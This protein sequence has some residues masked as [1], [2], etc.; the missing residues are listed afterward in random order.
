MYLNQI[1]DPVR[2]IMFNHNSTDNYFERY[3]YEVVIMTN[4]H[5]NMSMIHIS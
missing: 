1:I 4:I 2:I 3:E 5:D